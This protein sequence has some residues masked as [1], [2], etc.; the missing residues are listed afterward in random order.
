MQNS[1]DPVAALMEAL[2]SGITNEEAQSTGDKQP[3]YPFSSDKKDKFTAPP[4]DMGEMLPGDLIYSTDGNVWMVLSAP[5]ALFLSVMNELP[6][7]VPVLNIGGGFGAVIPK[8][9]YHKVKGWYRPDP[10][11]SKPEEPKSEGK[12]RLLAQTTY[13]RFHKG[14]F[15]LDMSNILLQA[16]RISADYGAKGECIRIVQRYAD[17]CTDDQAREIVDLIEQVP[18]STFK[19]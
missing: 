13:C 6:E 10:V 14:D 7:G 2:I 1:K 18:R 11:V 15:H 12:M 4:T 3:K 8:A 9:S 17:Y 16:I 5:T 19:F